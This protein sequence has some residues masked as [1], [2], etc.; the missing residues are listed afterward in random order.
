M[1]TQD[2]QGILAMILSIVLTTGAYAYICIENKRLTS[3]SGIESYEIELLLEMSVI[4][5]VFGLIYPFS[6]K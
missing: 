3:L 2:K 5:L 4:G 6:K 1:K